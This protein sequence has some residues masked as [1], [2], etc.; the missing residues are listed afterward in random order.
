MIV[1]HEFFMMDTT[2]R[3]PHTFH[4]LRRCCRVCVIDV[5]QPAPSSYRSRARRSGRT[6]R[7]S[8]T[9]RAST[10]RRQRYKELFRR[11]WPPWC[12]QRFMYVYVC[13][14]SY[15]CK[16]Y[17]YRIWWRDDLDECR[18]RHS[19]CTQWYALCAQCVGKK[20]QIYSIRC[21]VVAISSQPCIDL[22][23]VTF[24]D[25]MF[26]G[27]C[28]TSF[29]SCAACLRERIEM[30]GDKKHCCYRD[31][32]MHRC[33]QAFVPAQSRYQY[34]SRSDSTENVKG[35]RS[36]NQWSAPQPQPSQFGLSWFW[37]RFLWYSLLIFK[38]TFRW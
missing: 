31:G 24:M 29:N 16:L 23:Y 6:K 27:D 26:F 9:R 28:W 38:F 3:D 17:V 4:T 30:C 37:H 32:R 22:K 14:W 25:M 20:L 34:H 8:S 13:V 10:T 1:R 11:D 7:A 36:E 33:G 21:V 35:W 12:S 15:Y 2:A 5:E 18:A 19:S